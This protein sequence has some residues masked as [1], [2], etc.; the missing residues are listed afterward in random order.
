MQELNEVGLSVAGMTC[1]SCTRHVEDA[2]LAVPGV[3]RAAVDYPSNKAQVTGNRLD[4]SALVAAVGALG[5]GATPTDEF[6]SKERSVEQPG[7]L[8][9]AAQWLSGERAVEKPAGQLHVAIIGTGGAAVAAALKAAENGARVTLIERG[10]IGGT[11]VNVGCVPSKIMIRAAHIAHLRRESP[12]DVGLSATPPVVLRD[13][14]LAQQQA[15]VDELRHAKYESILESNPSINLVR[16]SARFKDGQ[17][18]IVEAA[19]GDTREVA[20]DR[21]LIATGASAAI[22][23]LPGLAGTPYWLNLPNAPKV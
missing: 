23:P 18:L 5:Y 11:C 19:E 22:P 14:L 4:V 1:P 2:L 16:G 17:T 9:K 13:R 10:T 20:F 12:F 21:C 8:G 7:L 6:E 3:T 15:R